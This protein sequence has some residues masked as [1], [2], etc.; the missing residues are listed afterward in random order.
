MACYEYQGMAEITW[1]DNTKTVQ[2]ICFYSGTLRVWP[3]DP[4]L[5]ESEYLGQAID[6]P[7]LNIKF[8]H[9]N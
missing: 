9:H 4:S 6:H 5:E 1:A 8:L 2:F 7:A 3:A